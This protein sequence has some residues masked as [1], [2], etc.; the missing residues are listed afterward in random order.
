MPIGMPEGKR[1]AKDF[2][3]AEVCTPP[4]SEDK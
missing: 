1:E 4:H 3:G 2:P